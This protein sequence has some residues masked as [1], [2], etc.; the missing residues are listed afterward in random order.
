MSQDRY[1]APFFFNPDLRQKIPSLA[2]GGAITI[3]EIEL[4]P[5]MR[6]LHAHMR[7]S[8][9]FAHLTFEEFAADYARLGARL[10]EAVAK[11]PGIQA[12]VN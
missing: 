5:G 10:A 8:T 7:A 12:M 1:T 9:R 6:L 2:H 4:D 3:G 11:D